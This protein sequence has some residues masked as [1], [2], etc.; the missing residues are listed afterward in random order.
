MKKAILL[1]FFLSLVAFSFSTNIVPSDDAQRVAKNFISERCGNYSLTESDFTLQY[2]ETDA[3]GEAVYYRFKIGNKGFIIISATN[4]VTPVLAYSLESDYYGHSSTEYI[5]RRYKSQIEYVKTH[6]TEAIQTTQM[7]KHYGAENFVA[8]SRK[9]LNAVEPL[10]TTTWDQIQYYNN[11]CPY[12]S[13]SELDYRV[14]VG[15]VAL[16][17]TN[18]MNYYRYPSSGVGGVSY[19]PRDYDDETGQLLYTYP[20]QT[21]NFS[22]HNYNYDAMTNSLNTYQ[23]EFAKLVYH[24]G[25]SVQMGYGV[26]GSGAQSAE[27]LNALKTYWKYSLK[28]ALK[29]ISEAATYGAWAIILKSELNAHRPVYYSGNSNQ[30]GGHAWIMDGYIDVD[31]STTYF[32]VNWGWSGYDNGF[33]LIDNLNTST[34]GEYSNDEQIFVD[35]YPADSLAIVKP[36]SSYTR[37]TASIGSICDGAGNVKYANNSYRQWMIAAPNAGTYTFTFSKIKTEENHDYITIYNGPTVASGIKARYSGNYLM[38]ACTDYSGATGSYHADYTG[39][40]LPSSV[41]VNA[42]SVLVVFESDNNDINDYGFLINYTT[43]FSSNPTCA[44]MTMLNTQSHYVISD[45]QSGDEGNYRA[46]TYC[47]WKLQPTFIQGFA[48]AF[49]K[50]ELKAGDFVDVF[51]NTI[52]SKP[53]LLWRFDINNFPANVYNTSC[54]KLLVKFVSDNWI[55]GDGF[56]LEY[57]TILGIDNQSGISDITLYPNPSSNN[58]YI[59]LTS[60]EAGDIQF[61]IFDMTGKLIQQETVSHNGGSLHYQTSVNDLA[62]GIYIMR[63]QTNKGESIRKFIVE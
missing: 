14:P 47:Q 1:I 10:V 63:I 44:S 23:G 41:T 19:V 9:F 43:S 20:R 4:L 31:Y 60:E 6:P 62:K 13:E 7:W 39:T 22:D 28:G 17:M 42:D 32:H 5:T 3:N 34:T 57:Y 12:N 16:T 38:P 51:D 27:A 30:G 50:F 54:T 46:Q 15:C 35:A 36:D 45:K 11:Y 48:F 25:V 21:V 24:S 53:E 40:A 26:D 55:E 29:S 33:F 59:D 18:L 37:N 49:T 61:R 2:T 52:T 8:S 58:I 56:E